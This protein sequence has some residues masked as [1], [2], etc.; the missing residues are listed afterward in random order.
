MTRIVAGVARGRRLSVPPAGTRPTA[1]RVREAMFSTWESRLTGLSG[2]RVADLFAGSGAVGLEALSR[3][4]ELAILVE[5]D[6]RAAAVIA[7]NIDAVGLPGAVLVVSDVVRLVG[8]PPPAQVGGPLDLVFLDPPYELADDVVE[9]V[10]TGLV[11]HGWLVD[12]ARVVVERSRRG[13]GFRWPD[14]F[15][16]ARDRQ[17]GDTMIR[18]A[19]WYR[20]ES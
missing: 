10:L 14:D 19:L 4:A 12:G 13:S 1:D 6:R 11:E 16:P 9:S 2:L 7:T 17:Y 3:G 5:S 15:E 20:R 18:T 8:A